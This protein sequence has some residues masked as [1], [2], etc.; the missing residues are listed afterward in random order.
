MGLLS[1]PLKSALMTVDHTVTFYCST[2]LTFSNVRWMVG[3]CLVPCS[4]LLQYKIITVTTCYTKPG[5]KSIVRKE[6]RPISRRLHRSVLNKQ[7]KSQHAMMVTLLFCLG[8]LRNVFPFHWNSAIQQPTE[9]TSVFLVR[10]GI[11]QQYANT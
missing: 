6:C 5:T 4:I 8:T 1:K 7:D 2:D 3:C 9:S 11:V 10:C